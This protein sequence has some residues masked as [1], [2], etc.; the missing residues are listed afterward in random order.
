MR[1]IVTGANGQL[2]RCLRG[3]FS[4]VEALFIDRD[5]VDLSDR[6]A[7]SDF[8]ASQ[9]CELVVNCAAFTDVDGA[10][11]D[12]VSAMAVNAMAIANI[13]DCSLRHNF[14]IIHISTDYVFDGRTDVPYRE[15]D[16]TAPATVYG[17]TKLEGERLLLQTNP[18]SVII[19][20][21][22]LYS[23]Y[24]R[25]FFLTMR[26]RAIDSLPSK[27]IDDQ[28]G[29]P[30]S[31]LGLAD[32]IRA[33]V[34]S[35]RWMPGIYHYSDEGRISWF[36]FA[37]EIYRLYSKN[38]ADGLVSPVSTADYGA[39]TPRPLFSVLDKSKFKVTF[40]FPVSDWKS[41]LREAAR[42][43]DNNHGTE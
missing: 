18:N 24:G 30:T 34:M 41:R 36:D 5:D 4:P 7:V 40:S 8:F 14:R 9:S 23:P 16:P 1:V 32:A 33:V 21:A 6:Q 13:A 42:L 11:N 29:S 22:W 43:T 3:K 37:R 2:G 26:R 27:V 20:T 38:G 31:A 35:D 15:T 12:R 19:R 17:Q 10:E 28:I 25:N 39:K